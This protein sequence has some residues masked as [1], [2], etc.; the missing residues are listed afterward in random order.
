MAVEAAERLETREVTVDLLNISSIKPLDEKA[1]IESVSKTGKMLTIEE[2]SIIGGLGSAVAEVL[3]KST[4]GKMDSI[5]I[6]DEFTETGPYMDLMNKY[7]ISSDHI[8]K[9]AMKMLQS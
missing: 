7:G 6:Q 1:I 5:G 2:H 9:K 8:Y 4:C 3:A